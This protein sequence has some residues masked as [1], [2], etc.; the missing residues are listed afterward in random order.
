[1]IMSK[2]ELELATYDALHHN[3]NDK[4]ARIEA[5]EKQIRSLKNAH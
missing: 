3:I 5:L 2:V 1:M 4:A